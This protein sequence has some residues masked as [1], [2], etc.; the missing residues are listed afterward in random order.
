MWIVLLYYT[1]SLEHRSV[2][3]W[4]SKFN[5]NKFC[6]S[7]RFHTDN[8]HGD[9]SDSKEC[10]NLT[11]NQSWQV[12]NMFF[13]TDV[14]MHWRKDGLNLLE[15]TENKLKYSAILYYNSMK[16]CPYRVK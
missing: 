2:Y 15:T 16:Y 9:V 3:V 13:V 6:S 12:K 10:A 7:K 1:L 14:Y 8:F 5:N 4:L 11:G